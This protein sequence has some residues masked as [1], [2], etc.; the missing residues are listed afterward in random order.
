MSNY[1]LLLVDAAMIVL[2]FVLVA[3]YCHR[4]ENDQ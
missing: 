1:A 4:A 3:M 2:C